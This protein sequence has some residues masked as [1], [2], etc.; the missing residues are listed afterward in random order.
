VILEETQF[1]PSLRSELTPLRSAS[2]LLQCVGEPRVKM[3]LLMGQNVTVTVILKRGS[4][5]STCVRLETSEE[6]TQ[7]WGI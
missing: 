4:T 7:V 6:G 1:C 3:G 2:E 5:S